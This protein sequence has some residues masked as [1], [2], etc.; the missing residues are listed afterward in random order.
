MGE[1]PSPSALS[2][3]E[4][5]TGGRPSYRAQLLS[6]LSSVPYLHQ[7]DDSIFDLFDLWLDLFVLLKKATICWT[8]QSLRPWLSWVLWKLAL[9]VPEHHS[10]VW[11]D[12]EKAAAANDK[13]C[14]QHISSTTS[15]YDCKHVSNG[16]FLVDPELFI[17][18]RRWSLLQTQRPWW[19]PLEE[20]PD[21]WEC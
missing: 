10:M 8:A 11:L 7:G 4:M 5:A 9:Q 1:C 18:K 20:Q 14:L 16:H 3:T 12:T 13:F 6:Q 2:Y 15:I 19:H 17:S 21:F